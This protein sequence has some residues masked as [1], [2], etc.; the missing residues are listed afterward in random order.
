MTRD[1]LLD[2]IISTIRKGTGVSGVELRKVFED[3][4][5]I[6]MTIDGKH[7][8]TGVFKGME[9]HFALVPGW[10]PQACYRGVI[11]EFLR[12]LFDRYGFLTTR[13]LHERPAQKE[14]VKRLGFKPTWRGE[15]VDYYMLTRLPFERKTP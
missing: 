13:V 11:R 8:A 9:L 4:E 15:N 3:W 14:F 10:K 6:P 12:P 1:E 2:P 5:V 7:V